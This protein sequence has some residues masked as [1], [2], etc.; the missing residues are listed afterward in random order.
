MVPKTFAN[1]MDSLAQQYN[2]VKEDVLSKS[3]EIVRQHYADICSGC[4]GSEDIIDI[5]AHGKRGHIS[6]YASC[7]HQTVRNSCSFFRFPKKKDKE[8]YGRNYQGRKVTPIVENDGDDGLEPEPHGDASLEPEPHPVQHAESTIVLQAEI[9]M[10]RRLSELEL[11]SRKMNFPFSHIKGDPKLVLIYTGIPNAEM[12]YIVLG[13]LKRFKLSYYYKWNVTD[14]SDE[15]QLFI[16][17]QKLR[18]NYNFLDLAV[19][20]STSETTVRNIFNTYLHALHESLFQPY[21]ANLGNIP[22]VQKMQ[23]VS[24]IFEEF[25]NCRFLIDCTEIFIETPRENLRAQKDTYSAYKKGQTFKGLIAVA[26]NGVICFV[27]KLYPGSCSDKHIVQDSEFCN[28]LKPGDLIIADKGF[29]IGDILPK[30]V[31]LNLPP[32]LVN[33][34]FTAQEAKY[35]TQIARARI[36]VERSIQRI[37]SFDILKDMVHNFRPFATVIFQVCAVLV[38]LQK[39]LISDE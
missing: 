1:H 7:N 25:P 32:F 33:P 8:R 26:P 16:A 23:E 9:D 28:C 18:L 35:T 13:Y 15:D 10:L 17:L 14:F 37:K 38:N 39:P 29:V 36:H 21:L 34:Q 5:S 24:P 12:F 22:S 11:K 20:Y 27:S 19:R 30:G 4:T 3:R 6:L 31:L 2:S